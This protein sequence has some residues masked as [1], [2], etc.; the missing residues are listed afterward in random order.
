MNGA[1][2][3]L[4]EE[5]VPGKAGD[6]VIGPERELAEIPCSRVSVQCLEQVIL[7]LRRRSVYH[8][9]GFE[10]QPDV[11]DLPAI[12]HARVGEPHM[13]LRAILDGPRKDFAVGE[14]L[15]PVTV[16]PGAAANLYPQVC[17]WT[18]QV[19]D[20]LVRQPVNQPALHRREF[21]P[22]GAR[23]RRIQLAGVVHELGK[24]V[25]GHL[26]VLGVC[27]SREQRQHP[28]QG[29][30][31]L[32]VRHHL[33][34]WSNRPLARNLA[35][36]VGLR[37]RL[38]V[39]LRYHADVHV[40]RA[41]RPLLNRREPC[42][43]L[44]RTQFKEI[45]LRFPQT[46]NDHWT[47]TRDQCFPVQGPKQWAR[48]HVAIDRDNIAGFDVRGVIDQGTSPGLEAWIGHQ[49]A[50]PDSSAV[51]FALQSR[52]RLYHRWQIALTLPVP[53]LRWQR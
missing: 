23:V 12:N 10:S 31:R 33:Q 2:D 7:A 5:N 19:H 27:I 16:D 53:A 18:L 49:V 11:L 44:I 42:D 25:R 3:L 50:S 21:P 41:T 1:A 13:A 20:L 40:G 43:L 6:V 26:G 24:G 39:L 52:V 51:G 15:V 9:A 46:G 22:R 28:A 36:Q 32:T 38:G 14:I 48:R 45:C 17:I 4:I 30:I 8:P 47:P 34:E 35:F 37:Q 29:S